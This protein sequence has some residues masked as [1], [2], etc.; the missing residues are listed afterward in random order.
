[1]KATIANLTVEIPE[2]ENKT[3]KIGEA[4]GINNYNEDATPKT[5][6]SPPNTKGDE[7]LPDCVGL[8]NCSKPEKCDNY[9][10]CIRNYVVA[11]MRNEVLRL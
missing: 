9:D 10:S 3:H 1:M 11:E 4:L 8:V 2:L 6:S 7:A 5:N